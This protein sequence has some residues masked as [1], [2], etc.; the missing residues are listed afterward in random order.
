M[1]IYLFFVRS[2]KRK[3]KITIMFVRFHLFKYSLFCAAINK[4]LIIIVTYVNYTSKKKIKI[5]I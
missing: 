3:N 4:L 2:F 5:N 1:F